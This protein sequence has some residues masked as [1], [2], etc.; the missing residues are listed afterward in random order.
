MAF[1]FVG[2]G[3]SVGEGSIVYPFVYVGAGARVGR[4]CVLG[5]GSVVMDGC[6]LG[7]R[8]RLA[9]GAVV[10]ADGFGYAVAPEAAPG[11]R[12]ERVPQ[13]G[14]VELSDDVDVGANATVDRAALGLTRVGAG[15]KLDNLVQIG[16]GATL[17]PDVAMAAC[18]GVAG[19][20]TLGRGVVVGAGAGVLG[21]LDV[22]AEAQIGAGSMVAQ[23]VPPGE[24]R[25]GMPAIPHTRWLRMMTMLPHLTSR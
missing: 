16:H 11:A 19:S 6:V 1:A 21:H 22:G 7:D 13:L 3:A 18:S 10:G 2:E 25:S 24:R 9:P 15:T 14:G 4:D 8:V 5:P 20:A 12:W 17:G 23:D